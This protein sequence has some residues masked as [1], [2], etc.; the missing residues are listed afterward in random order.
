M[1]PPLDLAIN[2]TDI[3]VEEIENL[4]QNPIDSIVMFTSPI[5][6]L[7]LLLNN[8]EKLEPNILAASP[9]KADHLL[10]SLFNLTNL[11]S[12]LTFEIDATVD[13]V[14][15]DTIDNLELVAKQIIDLVKVSE[16]FNNKSVTALRSPFIN[17][18]EN[19]IDRVVDLTRF[20]VKKIKGEL[21]QTGNK[22]S[23]AYSSLEQLLSQKENKS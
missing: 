7:V 21:I 1:Q 22:L 14:T 3:L 11:V 15:V 9:E 2:T 16:A 17:I 12:D 13:N 6:K 19:L 8:L 20:I 4:L 10:N 5:K 23:F 18:L